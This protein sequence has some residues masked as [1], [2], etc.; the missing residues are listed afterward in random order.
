M[1]TATVTL[2]QRAKLAKSLSAAIAATGL[3]L[4]RVA[5]EIAAARDLNQTTVQT[6]L[7]RWV[8]STP[9]SGA[10]DAAPDWI[11]EAI[12]AIKA[13]KPQEVARQLREAA[14]GGYVSKGLALR[15]AMAIEA[16]LR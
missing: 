15:G 5:I 1:P 12:A 16:L 2:A 11:F 14:D 7:K 10:I 3:S 13:A 6:N 8:S 4:R 9:R